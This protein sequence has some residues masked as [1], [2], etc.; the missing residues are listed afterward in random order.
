MAVP[1]TSD[2]IKIKIK[3]PNPSQ[4]PPVSSKALNEDLK[5]MDVLCTIKIKL[6]S[7]N[8]DCGCIK[9]HW[10]YPNQDQDAKPESGT[11]SI[12]Q[13]PKSGLKGHDSSL[14]LQNKDKEEKLRTVTIFKS[15][16]RYQTPVKN[17][18]HPPK[19]QIRTLGAQIVFAHSNIKIKS[20]NSEH[21]DQWPYSNQD[22]DAKS[23]SGASSVF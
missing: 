4:E 23:N 14:H 16:S 10:P 1:K 8:S 7:R 6:E 18:Q 20:Q 12:L 3:M 15:R 9:D 19:P 11:C 22:Q 13:S 21:K 2:H 5:E 17:L